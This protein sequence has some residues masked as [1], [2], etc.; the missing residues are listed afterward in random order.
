MLKKY[1][2]SITT[3]LIIVACG[4]VSVLLL[5]GGLLLLNYQ[6]DTIE[7]YHQEYQ[8]KITHTLETR[9]R[10]EQKALVAN[11][12]FNISIFSG[13]V[14][15]YLF[16]YNEDDMRKALETFIAY[17]EVLAVK[18]IDE[19]GKD[20][21]AAWKQEEILTGSTLPDNPAWKQA[22]M[23]EAEVGHMEQTV[24]NIKVYYTDSVLAAKIRQRRTE[25]L[26]DIRA[27]YKRSRHNLQSVVFNQII[28]V[29]ILLIILMLALWVSLRILMQKPLS[30]INQELKMLAKGKL[31]A[32]QINYK[33]HDEIAELTSSAQ[34]LKN[35]MKRTITQANAIAAGN[36]SGEVQL[37]SEHD[38]LGLAL[39]H[40]TMTLRDMTAAD[41]RREWFNNGLA[42]LDETTR[43]IQ[44]IND[45]AGNI[46]NFLAKYLEAQAGVFYIIKTENG[47]HCLWREAGY[48]LPAD[49]PEQFALG[50][51]LA[52]EVALSKTPIMVEEI[53]DGYMTIQSSIINTKPCSL[54]L[55]PLFHEDKL[56]G[57]LEI[58][59]LQSL[60]ER[61]LKFIEQAA[62][63][64]G[65]AIYTIL[66]VK[67]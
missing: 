11:L 34:S 7:I 40:M 4:V 8:E 66:A 46:I 36:Y 16:N 38:E 45:L 28:G 48:A 67:A 31:T 14:A 52:G 25:A 27:F 22:R 55:L 30:L 43:G 56:Q 61:S 5:T 47:Q 13:S 58:A 23:I 3:K 39:A 6:A 42:K 19:F 51:G 9:A 54:V 15:G 62:P 60:S 2:W 33:G 24:G 64:I 63:V 41:K 57:V 35:A 59:T 12:R 37:L 17:P 20:F 26:S 21:A 50:E 18:V 65:I 44:N 29:V 1:D 32:K 53:P 49:M 10:D